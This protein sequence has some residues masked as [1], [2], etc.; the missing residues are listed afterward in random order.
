[1]WSSDMLETRHTD[2]DVYRGYMMSYFSARDSQHV[3]NYDKSLPT[4]QL[5]AAQKNSAVW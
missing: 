3:L 1:M 5:E 2:R 4:Y